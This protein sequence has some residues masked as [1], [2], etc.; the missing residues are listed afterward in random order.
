MKGKVGY[1]TD[2]DFISY[3]TFF[4]KQHSA[5]NPNIKQLFVFCFQDSL[6]ANLTPFE[7]SQYDK[8]IKLKILQY[9]K[10]K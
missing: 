5:P 9:N 7:Y 10:G 3:F 1:Y 8:S 4:I 2:V 6:F